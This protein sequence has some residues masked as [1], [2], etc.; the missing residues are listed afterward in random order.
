ML[1]HVYF[2]NKSPAGAGEQK[3]LAAL[4]ISRAL[5]FETARSDVRSRTRGRVANC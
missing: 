2:Y 5:V 1:W 3:V 4:L